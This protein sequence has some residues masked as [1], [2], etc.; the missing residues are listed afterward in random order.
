[1]N[2]MRRLFRWAFSALCL[3]S[4]VGCVAMTL[5]LWRGERV[6][7]VGIE[8]AGRRADLEVPTHPAWLAPA[9]LGLPPIVWLALRARRLYARRRRRPG[10]CRRCGYDLTGNASGRCPECGQTIGREVLA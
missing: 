6:W 9:L 5:L 7:E 3:L 4:L 2:H 1:M 8:V 10:A